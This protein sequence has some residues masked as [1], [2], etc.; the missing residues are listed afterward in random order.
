V[1][2][3]DLEAK[4]GLSPGGTQALVTELEHDALVVRLGAEIRLAAD[5]EC[6][7][8]AAVHALTDGFDGLLG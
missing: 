5:A 3:A 7:L 4:L 8:L 6:E 1:T 2:I